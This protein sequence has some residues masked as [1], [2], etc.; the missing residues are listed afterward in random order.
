VLDRGRAR[1]SVRG[2]VHDTGAGP[3]ESEAAVRVTRPPSQAR[4]PTTPPCGLGVGRGSRA[5]LNGSWTVKHW[6]RPFDGPSLGLDPKQ[7]LRTAEAELIRLWDL[8]R[9][10]WN[11]G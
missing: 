5:G 11:R 8:R 10:G 7:A 2:G 9:V 6:V 4:C 3:E 1:M